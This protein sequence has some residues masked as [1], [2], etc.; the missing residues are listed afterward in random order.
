[1]Q[2]LGNTDVGWHIALGRWI[3]E[4]GEVPD[5]EPFSHTAAGVP[6]VA[7]EWLTQWLYAVA[8]DQFGLAGLQV[9]HGLIGVALVMLLYAC[10]RGCGATRSFA[11]LGVVIWLAIAMVRFQVRPHMINLLFAIVGYAWLFVVRPRLTRRQLAGCFVYAVVWANLHSGVLLAVAVTG[12]YAGAATAGKL[13]L[14]RPAHPDELGQDNLLRLWCLAVL[15]A[16][17]VLCTPNGFR[18]LPYLVETAR[19]NSQYSQ[20]WYSI[21]SAVGVASRS[22]IK[23]A[24]YCGLLAATVAVAWWRRR[25]VPLG[26][27]ALPLFFV[28]LPA[29]SGQRFTWAVFAA[30]VFAFSEVS[31]SYRRAS[32]WRIS[33]VA[34]VT[35]I[36]LAAVALPW[37][38]GLQ[39][40]TPRGDFNST[41]F[42]VGAMNFLD[43]IELAGNLFAPNKW[44][45]YVLYRTHD[46]YPVFIDGRWVTFGEQVF[47]DGRTL[48]NRLDGTWALLDK[49]GIQVLLVQRGW[50]TPEL[51]STGVLIPVFEN[52]NSGI[53]LWPGPARTRNLEVIANYYAQQQVPFDPV[54]GFDERSVLEASPE[55]AARYGVS[56]NH[57]NQFRARGGGRIVP[58]W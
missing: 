27:L 45:G 25:E 16:T 40:A 30:V 10:L 39:N 2:P 28:L 37:R 20:E 3:V 34:V 54:Q 5:R 35:A 19:L 36:A 47:R 42:P 32:G 18:L 51:R 14:K 52:F 48:T 46:R 56:R 31:T 29:V 7:H 43:D 38:E 13:I 22:T 53:Y 21:F 11:F 41:K 58:G 23:F 1:M 12:L 26:R 57:L 15:V 44:G 24:L 4:H 33:T 17:A 8:T 55:W 6:M 9:V 50:V 49:Y